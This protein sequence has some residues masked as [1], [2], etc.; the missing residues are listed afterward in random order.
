[1]QT[2]RQM[3]GERPR[4]PLLQWWEN[5]KYEGPICLDSCQSG[6]FE[7]TEISQNTVIESATEEQ[8]AT[9]EIL[10]ERKRQAKENFQKEKRKIEQQAK[11]SKA[12]ETVAAC[13]FIFCFVIFFQLCQKYET[14]AAIILLIVF[15]VMYTYTKDKMG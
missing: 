14:L 4:I 15:V 5:V 8:A 9:A 7:K 13:F 11:S 3:A 10:E 6:C 2:V 12:D 1:M